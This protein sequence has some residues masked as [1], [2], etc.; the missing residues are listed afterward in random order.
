MAEFLTDGDPNGDLNKT[1]EELKEYDKKGVKL[2]M[3][4]AAKYSKQLFQ[5]YQNEEDPYF[6]P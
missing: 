2:C 3:T 1:V 5:I 4:L 6:L